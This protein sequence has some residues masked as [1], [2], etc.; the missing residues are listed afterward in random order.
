MT[1]AVVD[2]GIVLDDVSA[3]VDVST[4][5]FIHDH[6]PRPNL[7]LSLSSEDQYMTHLYDTHMERIIEMVIQ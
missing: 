1:V 4:I 2:S 6:V 5:V 3:T 7:S